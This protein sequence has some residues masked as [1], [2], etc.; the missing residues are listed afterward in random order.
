M[1]QFKNECLLRLEVGTGEMN[2]WEHGQF[3]GE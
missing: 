3:L 1:R 2:R